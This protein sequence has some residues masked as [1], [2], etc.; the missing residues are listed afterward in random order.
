MI[1][2]CGRGMILSENVWTRM[3]MATSY[4]MSRSLDEK[5]QLFGAP[6]GSM[7]IPLFGEKGQALGPAN[8][9]SMIIALE[10]MAEMARFIGDDAAA[11]FY[12]AQAKLSP[13][14][15]DTLLWNETAGYYA[16]TLGS[17]GYDLMDIAQVLLAGIGS[18]QRQ[19]SFVEKLDALKVPAGYINGTR[20]SDTPGIVDPYYESFLLEG[21]ASTGRTELAQDLLDATWTPMVHRDCNYTGGYWEYIISVIAIPRLLSHT[22]K[23]Q[24]SPHPHLISHYNP[25]LDLFT[26]SSHF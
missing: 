18:E 8:T 4:A 21:L 24:D 5:T 6:V 15:I 11:E 13:T 1:T 7:G 19:A 26:G 14:A 22:P 10:K 17:T 2:G 16:A 9:V 25:G 20:L 3:V 12:L 23:T